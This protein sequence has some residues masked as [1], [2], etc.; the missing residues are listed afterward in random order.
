MLF[1]IF[2]LHIN[3]TK[4]IKKTRLLFAGD[5]G[6]KKC[7]VKAMKDINIMPKIIF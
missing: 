4:I 6:I 7:K 3:K 5:S 2:L 1:L